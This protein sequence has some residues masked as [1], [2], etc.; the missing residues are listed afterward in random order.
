MNKNI[1]VEPSSRTQGSAVM[2]GLRKYISERL[3]RKS[4]CTVFKQELNRLWPMDEHEQEKH[5]I[6]AFAMANGWTVKFSDPGL[7]AVFRKQEDPS[8]SCSLTV[9]S[10]ASA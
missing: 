9:P 10:S 1:S 3:A 2:A 5:S 6:A 8:V 7:R 4:F